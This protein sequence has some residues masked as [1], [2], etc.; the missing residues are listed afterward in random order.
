MHAASR[1]EFHMQTLF[2]GQSHGNRIVAE[3]A[4]HM[5]A[6]AA[7]LETLEESIGR[8]GNLKRKEVKQFRLFE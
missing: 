8:A 6:V 7:E 1:V 4:R 3:G 5:A 2:I